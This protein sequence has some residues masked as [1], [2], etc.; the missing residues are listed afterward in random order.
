[1]KS[2][3]IIAGVILLITHLSS[4][5]ESPVEYTREYSVQIRYADNTIDT[6]NFTSE[7]YPRMNIRSGVSILHTCGG[8]P[9][10]ASYI[11]SFKILSEKKVR[12]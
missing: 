10:M 1:M 11:K 12:S 9:P 3:L 4:C 5:S 6:L 8:R 7:C 2:I